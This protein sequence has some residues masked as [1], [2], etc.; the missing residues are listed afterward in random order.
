MNRNNR[1][2]HK[3]AKRRERP[4]R[5]KHAQRSLPVRAEEDDSPAPGSV[6][7]SSFASERAL[8]EIHQ[9]LE[10][11][12][13]GSKAEMNSFLETLLGD[14]LEKAF[15]KRPRDP[16]WQAQELAWQA[17]EAA[18]PDQ[19]ASQARQALALDPD[20]VDALVTLAHSTVPSLPELISRLREALAVTE[21]ALGKDFIEENRGQFWGITRTRP[22][23]RARFDLAGELLRAG[24]DDEA[25]GHFAA[26]LELNPNDNQGVRDILLG[27]YLLSGRME[28]ARVLLKKYERDYSAMFAWGRVLERFLSGDW[29]G[30]AAAL[31]NA[32]A[33]NRDVEQYLTGRRPPPNRLPDYYSPGKESEATYCAFYLARAWTMRSQAVQWLRSG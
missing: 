15:E 4:R 16:K 6:L 13:F 17:M 2:L 30:A 9:L 31:G 18:S 21:N 27:L 1:K 23:M 14:G 26:M 5:E 10:G 19:A 8:N 25:I 3:Q 33:R 22:Y 7:P 20:C 24:Q 12:E 11:R 28:E 32:R 29:D